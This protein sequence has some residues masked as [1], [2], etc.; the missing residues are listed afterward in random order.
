MSK[1][2]CKI[3]LETLNLNIQYTQPDNFTQ[4]Y[5]IE[6]YLPGLTLLE[7]N[8]DGLLLFRQWQ[9]ICELERGP[10]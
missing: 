4:I 9:M 10:W 5:K 2:Y 8:L 3:L 1:E 6:N 7:T